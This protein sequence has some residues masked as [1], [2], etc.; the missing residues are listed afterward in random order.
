[1][2]GITSRMNAEKGECS[3]RGQTSEARRGVKTKD[4]KGEKRGSLFGE[5]SPKPA[6]SK[7]NA[8][9]K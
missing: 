1:M 4:R 3:Q 9:P 2:K 6:E 8:K 7:H 5:Q